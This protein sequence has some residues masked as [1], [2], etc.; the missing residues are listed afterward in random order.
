MKTVKIL[1]G[2]AA[3]IVLVVMMACN[4]SKSFTSVDQMVSAAKSDVDFISPAELMALI[5]SGE[6]VNI[7]DVREPQEYNH[8]YIPGAINIPRGVLEFKIAKE[9]FWENEGLYLPE[10][11]ELFVLV[12]K[13]GG[14]STLAAQSI[15]YLDFENVKV[16]KDGWKNWEL[17]YPESFEKNL[18]ANA[19]EEE[20][21]VGGC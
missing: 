10:K 18:D 13:K 4:E 19:H 2:L 7:I 14:R 20:E 15:Q 9:E 5:D 1:F 12:C 11:E 8:G 21:E 16:L 17:S 6:T 3:L